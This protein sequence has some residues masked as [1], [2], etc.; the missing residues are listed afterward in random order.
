MPDCKNVLAN[1]VGRHRTRQGGP[2]THR[3]E[4]IAASSRT[5]CLSVIRAMSLAVNSAGNLD[6]QGDSMQSETGT[7]MADPS[8]RRLITA[9]AVGTLAAALALGPTQS[10]KAADGSVNA[11]FNSPNTYD[12][13]A[14][15]ITGRPARRHSRTSGRSSTTS[16]PTSS[17][18]RAHRIRVPAP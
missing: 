10:A 11:P 7:E 5:P 16:S 3:R 4:R 1:S 13:T 8:R 2:A 14:W 12:V 17:V 6:T 9:G 18:A 15:K